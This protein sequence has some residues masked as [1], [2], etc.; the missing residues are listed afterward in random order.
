MVINA[1][2]L[3]KSLSYGITSQGQDSVVRKLHKDLGPECWRACALLPLPWLRL[4]LQRQMGPPVPLS[5]PVATQTS[6]A[7]PPSKPLNQ[8]NSTEKNPAPNQS[9]PPVSKT[10]PSFWASLF[11]QTSFVDPWQFDADLVAK[12]AKIQKHSRHV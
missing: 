4:H 11:R 9:S 7:T 3:L 10:P 8:E 6:E 5:S 12:I 1:M 2:L